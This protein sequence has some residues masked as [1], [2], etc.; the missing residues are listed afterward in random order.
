[1]ARTSIYLNFMG[2]TE[3]AF[4]FYRQ[5]FGTELLSPLQRMRDVPAGPS[6]PPLPE[7]EK[8]MIMH[9]ELPILGGLVLMGTDMLESMGH[10][11]SIG[12]NISLNLEPD[13]LAETN[14]LYKALSEGGE[15]NMPLQEMF[16]GGYFGT[17]I[18]KFGVQ[19]M[20][21]CA[22]IESTGG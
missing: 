19:W 16:W 14:E 13:T 18:D 1:M 8:K 6:Q 3:E 10:R 17:C 2:K 7:D 11:L 4:N 22:N 12:N 21:N 20:F 9:V 15:A 5:V